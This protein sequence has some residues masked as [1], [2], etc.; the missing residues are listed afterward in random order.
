MSKP[1]PSPGKSNSLPTAPKSSLIYE[2]YFLNPCTAEHWSLQT[3]L[4]NTNYPN[5]RLVAK[6]CLPW[7]FVSTIPLRSHNPSLPHSSPHAGFIASSTLSYLFRE[8][9][10]PPKTQTVVSSHAPFG[11]PPPQLQQ[12]PS[13]SN[14]VYST[15]QNPVRTDLLPLHQCTTDTQFRLLPLPSINHHCPMTLLAAPSI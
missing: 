4:I 9:A 6:G 1:P 13:L 10:I 3:P 8:T 2:G 11:N 7:V 12:H 14:L 5:T 15:A